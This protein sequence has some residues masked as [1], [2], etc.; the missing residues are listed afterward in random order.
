MK[1][2][3][4]LAVVP[5]SLALA[6]ASM[7]CSGTAANEAPTVTAEGVA[8][9]APLAVTAHGQ[10]KLAAEAL[11]QVPLRA[12]QRAQIEKLAAHADG[13]HAAVTAAR[14]DLM[15]ALSSQ[16]AA[17]Q[18]D[19]SALAPKVDAIGAAVEAAHAGHRTALEQLHAILDSGQRSAFVDAL[20]GQV[21]GQWRSHMGKG[22]WEARW[23]ELNLTGDQKAQIESI[24][25]GEMSAM[26]GEW[27]AGHE[28]GAKILDAFRADSFVMDQ[29]APAEDVR[30]RTA[31]MTGHVIDVAQKVLPILTPE[32]RAIAAQKLET[33]ASEAREDEGAGPLL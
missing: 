18:I 25:H 29:V 16:V 12:D 22:G 14:K 6:L 27:K 3:F 30:T 8:T 1:G 9:K 19:A 20:K 11:A 26:K 13:Y 32:Q 33:R 15:L 5:V 10:V 21:A 17:G 7:G 24:V 4:R 23:A 31:Q 2:S 28:R